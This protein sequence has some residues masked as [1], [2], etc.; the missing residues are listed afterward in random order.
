[1]LLSWEEQEVFYVLLVIQIGSGPLFQC[2]AG[3]HS[4]GK[5]AGA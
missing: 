5:A 1:M 2:I 4:P 3:A